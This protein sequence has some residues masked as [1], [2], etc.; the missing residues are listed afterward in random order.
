MT[1]AELR[2]AT[3]DGRVERYPWK[4]KLP[5]PLFLYWLDPTTGERESYGRVYEGNGVACYRPVVHTP[6]S[7]T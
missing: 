2:L 4:A 5:A 1:T 7:A 3:R 6:E